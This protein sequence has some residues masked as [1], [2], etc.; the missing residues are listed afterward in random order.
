VVRT[1]S[2]RLKITITTHASLS[3]K[4]LNNFP[5]QPVPFSK[6]ADLKSTDDALGKGRGQ[7]DRLPDNLLEIL[8]LWQIFE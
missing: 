1:D 2:Y 7:G 4:P 3:Y 8:D 5:Q 6:V